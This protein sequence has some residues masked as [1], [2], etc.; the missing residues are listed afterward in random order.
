MELFYQERETKEDSGEGDRSLCRR[1]AQKYGVPESALRSAVDSLPAG[2]EN[3]PLTLSL[4][5]HANAHLQIE[6]LK[7]AYT[8]AELADAVI[9]AARASTSA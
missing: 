1:I 9:S 2:L 6:D 7:Q 5:R 8:Q 4:R 3:S